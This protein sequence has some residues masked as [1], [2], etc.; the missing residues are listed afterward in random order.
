MFL[1]FP[2]SLARR[3]LGKP[4]RLVA[5]VRSFGCTVAF[6]GGKFLRFLVALVFLVVFQLTVMLRSVLAFLFV[7]AFRSVLAFVFV[8]PCRSD[9]AV[10]GWSVLTIVGKSA[11]VLVFVVGF[12]S[13]LPPKVVMCMSAFSSVFLVMLR[14]VT[15]D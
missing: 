1:I 12:R 6:T 11:S 4:F 8:V 10:G 2:V 3:R 5:F 7:V 13:V 9:L 15:A 14:L